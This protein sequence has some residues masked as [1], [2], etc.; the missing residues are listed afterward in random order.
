MNTTIS[1][2]FRKNAHL[3]ATVVRKFSSSVC[4][5]S[6]SSTNVIASSISHTLNQSHA[7]HSVRAMLTRHSA[8]SLSSFQS[9]LSSLPPSSFIPSNIKAT[10]TIIPQLCAVPK[11]RTSHSKVRIRRGGLRAK[12]IRKLYTPYRICLNCGTPVRPH[13]L[14]KVCLK[15]VTHV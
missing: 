9:N 2:G 3:F 12:Y 14:C 10:T 11:K 1:F 7:I 4:S 15:A 8:H 6:P 13:Y 5:S